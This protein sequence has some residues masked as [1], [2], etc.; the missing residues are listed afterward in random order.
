MKKYLVILLFFLLNSFWVIQDNT[1]PA[2]GDDARWLSETANLTQ[3]V[4]SGDSQAVFD[5]WENMFVKDTNSFPRTPLFTAMSVPSFLVFGI[6]ENVAVITNVFVL[7]ITSLLLSFF[8]EELFKNNSNR[9]KISL[10]AIIIFN[11]MAGTYGLSRLYM[12][13][14]LQ[15]A[16]VILISFIYLKFKDRFSYK[17]YLFLGLLWGLALLLRFLMPMYLIVPSLFFLKWQLDQKKKFYEYALAIIVF[18]IPFLLTTLTWYGQNLTTYIE[19]TRYTSSGELAEI[20]SLGPVYSPVT[21]FKYWKVIGLWHFGLPI[22]IMAGVSLIINFFKTSKLKLLFAFKELYFLIWSFLPALVMTTLSVNKTARYFYPV[23][24]FIVIIIAYLVYQ[25]WANKNKV[26]KLIVLFLF[27]LS[28][29]PF[30]N[31]FITILPSIPYTNFMYS[32]SEYQVLDND[33]QKYS[34]II[35]ELKKYPYVEKDEAYLVA[36]TPE[37]NDAQILWYAY[38]KGE[39]INTIGEFSLYTTLDE[40]K[41]KIDKADLVILHTGLS[42]EEKYMQK[43]L[44][45]LKYVKSNPAFELVSDK[46]YYDSS[47]IMIFK[48]K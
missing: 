34:F 48:R 33:E 22:L 42:F 40:G 7:A 46:E 8:V 11:L 15:T 17:S 14:I 41:A 28:F 21:W 13:E 3:I 25:V 31:S 5:K 47:S 35:D 29:Y 18:L 45:A 12:S 9:S 1:L 32:S 19:F 2:I 26:Y 43:Y 37:V 44:D 4:K 27:A 6:N 10:F 39:K 36:E 20:T 38:Q 23:E 24:F 30:L 16:F